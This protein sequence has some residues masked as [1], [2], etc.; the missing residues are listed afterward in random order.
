MSGGK[1]RY[2]T[3]Y[4]SDCIKI[5]KNIKESTEHQNIKNL[6]QMN[7]FSEDLK[8]DIIKKPSIKYDQTFLLNM[9]RESGDQK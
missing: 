1:N 5:G 6:K 8:R 9:V 7:R 3:L 4:L 2:A